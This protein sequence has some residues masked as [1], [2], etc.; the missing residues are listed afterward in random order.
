MSGESVTVGREP[1][2]PSG[3]RWKARVVL[4]LVSATVLGA[5]MLTALMPSPL[6][7]KIVSGL[8]VLVAGGLLIAHPRTGSLAIDG[9][10]IVLIAAYPLYRHV[11][12]ARRRDV[13]N[14]VI[15]PSTPQLKASFWRPSFGYDLRVNLRD[16]R[17]INLVT[18]LLS[19]DLATP[20]DKVKDA[21]ARTPA[22]TKPDEPVVGGY[23]TAPSTRERVTFG[24]VRHRVALALFAGLLLVLPVAAVVAWLKLGG[25]ISASV[26]VPGIIGG[27]ML[28]QPRGGFFERDAATGEVVIGVE[29]LLSRKV[30]RLPRADIE[31]VALVAEENEWWALVLRLTNG[32]REILWRRQSSGELD[33]AYEEISRLLADSPA[34]RVVVPEV[35][36]PNV[37][38]EEEETARRVGRS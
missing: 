17:A 19:D 30:R 20:L 15:V 35:L 23:R 32:K 31:G 37:A 21:L 27:A 10:H 4:A 8:T 25:R 22:S 13:A 38:T 5:A 24:A 11:L 16:G 36:P 12:R 33:G 18:T 14:V 29:R 1:L 2:A 26:L 6:W 9:E 7:L 3:D 34:A 28:L